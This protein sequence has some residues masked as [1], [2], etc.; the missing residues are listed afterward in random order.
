MPTIRLIGVP[1][2]WGI[3]DT[4]VAE[5]PAILRAA[6]LVS[7]LEVAGHRVE[8]HGDVAVPSGRDEDPPATAP[9]TPDPP[10]L[11]QVEALC[12]GVRQALEEALA[13]RH[14]P[15]LVGGECSL[16]M[17]AVP[18]LA[19]QVGPPTIVWLDAHGDLNTPETSPSGLITGMPLA[20]L[21]GRGHRELLELGSGAPRPS[22]SETW[23]LGARDL[24]R[25]E[26]ELLE[27]L[28]LHRVSVE[29]FRRR[30]AEVVA[31]ELLETPSAALLPP[32]ARPV[33]TAPERPETG[34]DLYLHLDVDVLD[35]ADA[36]GVDY[37]VNDGLR[38][39][40]VAD[41]VGYLATS[42]RLAA[43]AMASA[44]LTRDADGT[45]VGNLRTVLT[46]LADGLAAA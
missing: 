30:G 23:I 15:L 41:L 25:G 12:R 18:A 3:R 33:G 8:D 21:L 6:G 40:E 32:E 35:P 45:T 38:T 42:G 19:G 11:Q 44:N 17:G 24:D 1:S 7:W 4:G 13:A 31:A 43:L 29:E 10:H 16:A 2:A 22:P 34:A 26:G 37:R 14:F 9:D 20:V 36:P 28:G 39:D 46:S 27:E 5:T